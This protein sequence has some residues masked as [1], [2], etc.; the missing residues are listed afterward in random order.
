MKGYEY[1]QVK[2]FVKP[3][4]YKSL[5]SHIDNNS[6][7]VNVS[8]GVD[9]IMLIKW[10]VEKKAHYIDTSLEVY[11][12][13]HKKVNPDEV[14]SYSDIIQNNLFHQNYLAFKAQG[15][16]KTTRHISS[17]MNPGIISHFTKKALKEYARQ[18]KGMKF[19]KRNW[20]GDYAKLAHDLG[21]KEVQV[22]E[23]DSQKLKVKSTPN[24]FVN[25]WSAI[26]Y[27]EE[28]GDLVMLSLNND[29][30]KALRDLGY[31]LIQPTEKR[32]TG[33]YFL[34]KRGMDMERRSVT[35]DYSGNPFEYKGKLIPHA[36][37][38]SLSEFLR[39]NHNSPTIMYI[40]RSSD[41]SLKGLDY[42]RD[43]DYENLPDW[44]VVRKKDVTSGWD[45]IGAL[46]HFENGDKF[47]GWTVCGLED[48]KKHGLMS[49]PTLLQVACSIVP[50][51]TWTLK[52]RQMGMNNPETVPHKYIFDF[53]NK[54]LGKLFF[55]K[56]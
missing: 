45:S 52:H 39:Y 16:D 24:M 18:V 29:D 42:Y 46:L 21:L 19:T 28:A 11:A 38:V 37:I 27:Q 2:E 15:K 23:Y 44:K 53:A 20:K 48:V 3:D 4:N 5:L 17:A 55:K 30:A 8:I 31:K 1:I 32:D 7:L 22:V 12:E 36:E 35:L 49:G 33:I 41:E 56:L 9:S 34:N 40:Y 13:H 10:C 26:G 25:T 43:N 14:R 51:I 50:C 6:F 47:G 54:Y